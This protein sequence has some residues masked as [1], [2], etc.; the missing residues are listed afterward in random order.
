MLILQSAGQ[1][2]VAVV[3][4]LF[5]KHVGRGPRVVLLHQTLGAFIR[6]ACRMLPSPR[7]ASSP[8]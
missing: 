4:G 2:E 3:D 1:C 5:V 8:A 6:M 7:A